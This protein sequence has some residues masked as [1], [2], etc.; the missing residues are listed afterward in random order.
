MTICQTSVV[1]RVMPRIVH[2][3]NKARVPRNTSREPAT[4]VTLS[5][6]LNDLVFCNNLWNREGSGGGG[7]DL[8]C[9]RAWREDAE[10]AEDMTGVLSSVQDDE[11]GISWAGAAISKVE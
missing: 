10:D 3:S 11:S 1:P 8:N 7:G 4:F 6:T 9:G 2:T 5:K